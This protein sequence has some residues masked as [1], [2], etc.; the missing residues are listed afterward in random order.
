MKQLQNLDIV[1]SVQGAVITLDIIT[2]INCVIEPVLLGMIAGK[3]IVKLIVIP[4]CN[5]PL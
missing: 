4:E 5:K 3:H 1:T 2:E